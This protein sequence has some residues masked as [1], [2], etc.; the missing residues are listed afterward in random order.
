VGSKNGGF[1][2]RKRRDFEVFRE[3]ERVFGGGKES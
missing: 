3:R 2:E 1:L